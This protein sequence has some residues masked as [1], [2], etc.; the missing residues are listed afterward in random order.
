MQGANYLVALKP[1]EMPRDVEGI[2]PGSIQLTSGTHR[3]LTGAEVDK[4]KALRPDLHDKLDIVVADGA[5]PHVPT[6]VDVEI[7]E[8][9]LE[10][11]TTTAAPKK[12]VPPKKK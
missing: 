7:A 11:P 2:R 5:T 12:A 1:G 8:T 3:E 4:L 6:E 10:E 9:G